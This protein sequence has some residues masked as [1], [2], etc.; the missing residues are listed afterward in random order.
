[1]KK[2][3]QFNAPFQALKGV[4]VKEKAQ[5]RK[6]PEAS[7]AATPKPPADDADLFRQAMQGVSPIKQDRIAP[8]PENPQAYV[9]AIRQNIHPEDHAVLAELDALVKG[10]SHFDITATGEY[11]EGHVASINPV[12]MKR[13]KKGEFALQ[14]HLDLHGLTRDEA[15]QTL[16]TFIQN[17]VAL[18]ERCLLVIHGRGLKS[19][20]G[21]VLKESVITWLTT[22][23]LAHHVLALCSAQPYDGGTGAL[24]VLL[25]QRPKKS[26]WKRPI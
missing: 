14:G 24:Y 4:T 1:M 6:A 11:V 12:I 2:D 25:R 15:R 13:L 16:D 10:K 17:A 23:R 8:E 3:P 21:P 9:R 7:P 22:G 5:R 19:P 18:S 26:Q 20:E